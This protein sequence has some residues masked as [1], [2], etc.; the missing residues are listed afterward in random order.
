MGNA[1]F[2]L[3][4]LRRWDEATIPTEDRDYSTP[5]AKEDLPPHELAKESVL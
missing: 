2:H 4:T 5:S 1:L 3:D